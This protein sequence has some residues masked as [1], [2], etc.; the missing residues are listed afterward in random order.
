MKRIGNRYFI[1]S[2]PLSVG[3]LTVNYSDNF[4]VKDLSLSVTVKGISVEVI[5]EIEEVLNDFRKY[6]EPKKGVN[7]IKL[8]E[9]WSKEE[10]DQNNLNY[11]INKA[12]KQ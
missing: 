7:A 6:S 2:S 9:E 3:T 12:R 1:E 5:K 11:I 8:R 10:E 4:I